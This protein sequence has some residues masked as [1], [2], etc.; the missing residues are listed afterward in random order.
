VS[1][2]DPA[3]SQAK[4]RQ[5]IDTAIYAA[6]DLH[7]NSTVALCPP[8]IELD[9]GGTYHASRVQRWLH[10][11]FIDQIERFKLIEARRKVAILNGDIAEL[12]TKRRSNQIISANK[13]TIKTMVIDTISPL[14][15]IVDAVFI[16]RGTPAHTGKSGWIEEMIAKD[17]DNT[18]RPGK[19]ETPA[20][21]YHLRNIFDGVRFDVAHHAS[22]GSMPWTE[23]NAAN[24]AATK[25]MWRYLIDMK[26]PAPHIA[27]RSH[28]HRFC[29]SGNNYETRVIM[30][31][32]WTVRTEFIYRIGGENTVASVGSSV[33][34]CDK[35][36][37]QCE[38]WQV[39]PKEVR[40]VW[41]RL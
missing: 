23:K 40:R 31:D 35:G 13:D 1:G 9:D 36:K 20:S 14:V 15:D 10:E 17:F 2:I 29:D 12:D 25:I 5:V 7:T 30:L 11:N 3:E 34:L 24:A 28:N 41:Q 4:G 39:E 27:L 37:V 21:W 32:A 8:K 18:I 19:A 26:Q 38:R 33:F 22:M 16:I 6:G